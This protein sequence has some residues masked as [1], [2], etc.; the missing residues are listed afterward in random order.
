MKQILSGSTKHNNVFGDLI[1]R[2][3]YY[4]NLKKFGPLLNPV[5]PCNS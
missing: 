5:D 4:L 3:R 1:C 2:P